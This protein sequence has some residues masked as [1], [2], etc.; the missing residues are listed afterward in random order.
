MCFLSLLFAGIALVPLAQRVG[1][2]TLLTPFL[3]GPPPLQVVAWPVLGAS[4]ALAATAFLEFIDARI[5]WLLPLVGA[6]AGA[7]ATAS[8]GTAVDG[9]VYAFPSLLPG[10]VVG[11]LFGTA[12][13]FPRR[14]L[15]EARRIVAAATSDIQVVNSCAWVVAV[16]GLV[17]PAARSTGA[18]CV[19]AAIV[20]AATA[21]GALAGLRWR[22]RRR[23]LRG[24]LRGTV[25]GLSLE[26]P[27]I[28]V[29]PW[30]PVLDVL[31]ADADEQVLLVSV[32]LGDNPYR[33]PGAQR[34]CARLLPDFAP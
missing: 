5:G 23:W 30:L 1:Y 16:A 29:A 12:S 18:L 28:E 31:E 2:V 6:L 22:L 17:A 10:A 7:L 9:H 34:A 26:V 14:Q 4:L 8:V 20:V 25:S 24:V 19:T 21:T 33:S 15:R 13:I 3:P 11:L 32:P 27:A